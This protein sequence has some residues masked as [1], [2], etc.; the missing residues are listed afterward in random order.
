MSRINPEILRTERERKGWSLGDLARRSGID[1]QSIHR[2]EK[3]G[4]KHNRKKVIADLARALGV[5]EDSLTVTASPPLPEEGVDESEELL[6][7]SQMNVRVSNRAR[8]A[9]ALVADRYGVSH[10]QIGEIAPLL[11]CWAAEQSLKGRRDRLAEIDKMNAELW[12]LKARHLHARAFDNYVAEAT[13]EAE[14][15]S[16]AKNDV[17]GIN[18]SGDEFDSFLPE[19]YS[20]ATDNPFSDFLRGLTAELGDLATFA[21]WDPDDSPEYTVCGSRVVEYL[22]GDRE[23][24]DEV[25]EG[26]V[27]LHKLPKELREEGKGEARAKWV[28]DDVASRRKKISARINLDDLVI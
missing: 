22:A 26:Y 27:L 4:Q 3:G 9:F 19:N 10:A 5:Y 24:A 11:F 12:Q 28:R 25:L 14:R 17:F 20:E 1:A 8:N 16:I 7:E 15:Q 13:L 21:E 23:A 18:I 6:S 2:I